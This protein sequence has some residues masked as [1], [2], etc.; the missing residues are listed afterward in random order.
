MKRIILQVLLII[1]CNI[2]VKAMEANKDSLIFTEHNLPLHLTFQEYKD[3]E[4][5][6]LRMIDT[7]NQE[8]SALE[9]RNIQ[10]AY[11]V[12]D[13]R[14]IDYIL[15]VEAT[16]LSNN[17]IITN[18]KKPQLNKYQQSLKIVQEKIARFNKN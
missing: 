15:N 8:I 12:D 14:P 9:K 16:V 7:V 4:A 13:Y 18:D 17:A 6:L 11:N 5:N 2:T 1:T 10:L 3:I